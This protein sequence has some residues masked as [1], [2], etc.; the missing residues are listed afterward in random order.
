MHVGTNL[1][2]TAERAIGGDLAVFLA[3][4]RTRGDSWETITRELWA[5]YGVSVTATGVRKWGQK[6]G[7]DEVDEAT[8]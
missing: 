7:M 1:W 3:E 4:R 2:R 8:A 5:D 6:L